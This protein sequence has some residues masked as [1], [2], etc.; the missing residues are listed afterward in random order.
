MRWFSLVLLVLHQAAAPAC[1]GP[2]TPP[3][4]H[5]QPYVALTG[6]DSAVAAP[7]YHRLR[8]PAELARVWLLH[9]GQPVP[10]G[11]HD[12][13]YNEPGVPEVDFEA[14]EVVAIFGGK[15][16]NSAG[17]QVE[18]VDDE[19]TCRRL[20]FDHRSY[21]TEGPTGG[22]KRV[23]PYGF[24]VLPRTDLPLVLEEDVQSLIGAPPEWRQRAQ[25]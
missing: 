18:S 7:A 11:E 8:T 12:F 2:P 19:A 20:R 6:A 15:G 5:L 3:L 10:D 14:C 17:F 1:Q 16:W 4:R 23:T 22:G 13:F 21:Q 9:L 25:L 24:F